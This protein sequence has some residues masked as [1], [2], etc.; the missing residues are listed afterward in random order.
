[1]CLNTS[2]PWVENEFVCVE[3]VSLKT[4]LDLSKESV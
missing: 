4:N 3:T 1:M 2:V